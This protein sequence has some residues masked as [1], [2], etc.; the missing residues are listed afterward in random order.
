[1]KANENNEPQSFLEQI[2]AEPSSALCR[3]IKSM[4]S[5]GEEKLSEDEV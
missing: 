3:L 1:M 5:G 4:Q 2:N